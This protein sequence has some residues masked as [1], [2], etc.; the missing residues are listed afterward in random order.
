M[1]NQEFMRR[2]LVLAARGLG[3]TAPNPPVGA[4]V[5]R[6]GEVVGEGW[7]RRAGEAHAE[8]QA[9]HAAGEAAR[10]ADLYCT[11]EPCCHHGRTPPCT[12]AII[13]SGIARVFYA[14]ADPDPRC[15]GGGA[16]TLRRA[17]IEVF[18]GFQADEA[19]ELYEP[20]FK[21]K[22][23]GLPFVTLKLACTL[24]GKVA[25]RTGDS[26]W[27]TGEPARAL[28]HQWRDQTDAIMVGSG[29][30]LADDPA[31]TARGPKQ[32][33]REPWRIVIDSRGR[34]PAEVQV[35]TG[36]GRCL[37]VRNDSPG[38]EPASGPRPASVVAGNG[39]IDLARL[40]AWLGEH[41][42]MSVL[43]EG[44]PGL[45]GVLVAQGLV[46]K[47]RLFYAPKLIGSEGLSAIG[48]L[49]LERMSEAKPLRLAHVD[50]IGEDIL[51]TAY[52]CSQD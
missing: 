17:G 3:R 4:V 38:A 31:L 8:P 12:D 20:Y 52:P 32:D 27:I 1:S 10:G 39:H 29:T 15:A 14:A 43:V 24:D 49:G 45:A 23:T 28:V 47:Y 21:H 51:V 2:A 44:G 9:L 11:L 42:V 30:V 35:L 48:G 5:V 18:A 34:V 46:D 37:I 13:E 16:Q 22:R 41:D 19:A 36:P 40:L 7:H 33:D 25:T 50:L 26:R 6:N